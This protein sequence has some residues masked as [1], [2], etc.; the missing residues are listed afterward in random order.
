MFLII[1]QFSTSLAGSKYAFKELSAAL[2]EDQGH[3]EAYV[4]LVYSDDSVLPVRVL[5]QSL[6]K[7][8]TQR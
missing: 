6:L 1:L 8:E 5:G 7:T 3:K 2:K 4:T